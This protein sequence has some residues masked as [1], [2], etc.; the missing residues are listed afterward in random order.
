VAVSEP[1]D[2]ALGLVNASAPSS[3]EYQKTAASTE[4][5]VTGGPSKDVQNASEDLAAHIA[6]TGVGININSAA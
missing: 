4:A 2:A 5:A 6:T 1:P 3:V